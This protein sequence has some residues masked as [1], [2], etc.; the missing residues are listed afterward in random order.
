MGEMSGETPKKGRSRL[1]SFWTYT[2]IVPA[3]AVTPVNR[4]SLSHQTL[5]KSAHQILDALRSLPL[6]IKYTTY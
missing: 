4:V 1:S 2:D 6:K 3:G 5:T